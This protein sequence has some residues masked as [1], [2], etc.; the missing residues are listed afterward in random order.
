MTKTFKQALN[1]AQ[2]EI[3]QGNL[4]ETIVTLQIALRSKGIVKVSQ[5]MCHRNM[6]VETF[7]NKAIKNIWENFET[8]IEE[9]DLELPYTVICK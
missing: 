7:K 3:R 2:E 1:H 5:F 9:S 4:G 6:D 8:S